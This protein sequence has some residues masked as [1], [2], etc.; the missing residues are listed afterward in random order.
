MED[1]KGVGRPS[2]YKPE[3]AEKVYKLCLL[4]AKDKEIA[5][6]FDIAEST[7][8]LWKKEHEEFS[9]SIKRGKDDADSNV[10]DRLYQR[11]MGYEHPEDQIFQ[12]QGKPVVVPTTKHY[13]PDSTAAIF[14]LKNRQRG[15]WSDKTETELT[16]ANGGPIQYE[17]MSAEERQKRIAELLNK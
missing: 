7:L 8:N 9:E 12:Y 17:A 10:A 4:G 6:I 1:K 11:A 3:Y 2:A 5:E 14:W 16:G 15:K 13:P